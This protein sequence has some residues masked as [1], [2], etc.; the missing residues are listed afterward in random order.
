MNKLILAATITAAIALPS[1]VVAQ[2]TTPRT[3]LRVPPPGTV[4]CRPI[5]VGEKPDATMGTVQLKCRNVNVARIRAALTSIHSM[6]STMTPAQRPQMQ[7]SVQTLE[8]ELEP[9][10][11]GNNGGVED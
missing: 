5:K 2:G 1:I 3:T 7:T 11:P 10:V 4:V 8:S 9:T 6:M